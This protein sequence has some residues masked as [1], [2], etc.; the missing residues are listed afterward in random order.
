MKKA[1][2]EIMGLAIIVVLIVLGMIFV[3]KFRIADEPIQYKE[4][5]TQAKLASNTVASLLRVTS[6]CNGLS[7]TQLL[8]NCSQNP[9]DSQVI[10]FGESSCSFFEDASR[11]IFSETLEKWNVDYEFTVFNKDDNPFISLG[12]TCLSDKKSKLFP[13]P[14]E[15][16]IVF[17]KMDICG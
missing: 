6:N 4:Q 9:A 8:Q 17:V 3:L 10:C 14:T 12:R 13:I 16:E 5:F 15:N 11:Q 1:Q 7:M 2:V